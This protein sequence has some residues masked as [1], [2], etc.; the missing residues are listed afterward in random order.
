MAGTTTADELCFTPC[1]CPCP[2]PC[3][4]RSVNKQPVVARR[5]IT[6]DNTKI[7]FIQLVCFVWWRDATPQ[8]SDLC[9]AEPCGYRTVG[10]GGI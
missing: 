4:P 2:C 6:Q 10:E 1:P 3:P 5:L 9:A 7:F 8:A